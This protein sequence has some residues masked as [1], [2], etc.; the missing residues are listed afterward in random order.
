MFATI[1]S[2][3]HTVTVFPRLHSQQAD[4]DAAMH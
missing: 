1:K 4:S 3:L 2:V